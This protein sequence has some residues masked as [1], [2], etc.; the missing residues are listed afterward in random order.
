[1]TTQNC[2]QPVG[3]VANSTDCDDANNQI[4]P[5]ATEV[6]DGFD[7]NCDLVIDEGFTLTTYYED[8]DGDNYGWY[9]KF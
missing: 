4:N 2:G 8:L 1:M 3:Y 6:F 9:V 5:N 7:N